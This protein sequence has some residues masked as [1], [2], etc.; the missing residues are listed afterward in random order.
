MTTP[1]GNIDDLRP[2]TLANYI[3]QERMKRRLQVRI[4]A[5]RN[6]RAYCAATTEAER[7]AAAAKARPLGHVLLCGPPGAGK[8][9]LASLIA[10]ELSDP[11]M[12]LQMPVKASV[13]ADVVGSFT[14]V[15]F[16]EELHR[17]KGDQELLLPLLE[18][19]NFHLAN[20]KIIKN[21][22]LTVVGA[23]TE[24]DQIIAPLWARFSGGTP[25]YEAYTS[26]QLARIGAGMAAK[27]GITLSPDLLAG[28]GRAAGGVPRNV[29]NL[30]LEARDLIATYGTEPTINQLLDQAGLSHDGL[31]DSHMEYLVALLKLGGVAGIARL[32]SMVRLDPS[33]LM[34][35][36]RLLIDRGLVEF[37]VKGRELTQAGK[38]RAKAAA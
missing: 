22:W 17:L 6:L 8:T 3:G 34:D 33:V 35:L 14:G 28:I 12:A 9:S 4:D 27:L 10:D 16:L 36:E 30:I 24:R 31:T 20:G 2:D 29:K 26:A 1:V 38:A 11:F 13:L 37:G 19:G 15:L 7:E 21:K 23:T 32:R 5:A 25:V 18:F